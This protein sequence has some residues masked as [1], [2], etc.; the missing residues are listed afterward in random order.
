M[1]IIAFRRLS[2]TNESKIGGT[3]PWGYFGRGK[4][5]AQGPN[6][7][8]MEVRGGFTFKFGKFSI[9]WSPFLISP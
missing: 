4:W 8:R 6:L 9:D 3:Y 2:F 5:T 7:E 1:K